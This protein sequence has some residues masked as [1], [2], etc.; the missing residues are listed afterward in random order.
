MAIGRT[1]VEHES[2]KRRVDRVWVTPYF[3]FQLYFDAHNT[4]VDLQPIM[5]A[6]Q[7]LAEWKL[8]L[9]FSTQSPTGD[10]LQI[11]GFDGENIVLGSSDGRLVLTNELGD[12]T[13]R[14]EAAVSHDNGQRHLLELD[15][16]GEGHYLYIDGQ[17]LNQMYTKGDGQVPFLLPAVITEASLGK[18][19]LTGFFSGLIKDIR[20]EDQ[21]GTVLFWAKMNDNADHVQDMVS[22]NYGQ[23]HN[24][25][26]EDG[27]NEDPI[28]REVKN[29]YVCREAGQWENAHKG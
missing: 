15:V 19:V 10:L 18:G 14:I 22:G 4:W 9:T 27:F 17:Y 8:F 7:G 28:F 12:D 1:I 6:V 24:G 23:V 26:W 16:N 11:K 13:L 5:A 25:F 29:T 2:V 21:A 3:D 20:I